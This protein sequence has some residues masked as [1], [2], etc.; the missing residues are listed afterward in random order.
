MAV[1]NRIKPLK[2]VTEKGPSKAKVVVKFHCLRTQDVIEWDAAQLGPFL[3][4]EGEQVTIIGNTKTIRGYVQSVNNLIMW[5]SNNPK[6]QITI[7][8]GPQSQR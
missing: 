8:V 7:Y 6:T 3:P 5:N 1:S 4:R 2:P